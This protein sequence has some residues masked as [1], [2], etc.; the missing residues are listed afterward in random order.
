MRVES[1]TTVCSPLLADGLELTGT[2][3]QA[4]E[5]LAPPEF[6][7]RT[8]LRQ[9]NSK[10]LISGFNQGY[11]RVNPTLKSAA[12][13]IP[14]TLCDGSTRE[15]NNMGLRKAL[16]HL[17]MRV[18]RWTFTPGHPLPERCVVL[19]APHTSNWDGFYMVVAM[20]ALQRPFYFLV[21]KNLTDVPVI[22]RFVQAIGGIPVDRENPG[23]LVERVIALAQSS[24]TFVLVIAP[25]GTR[26]IRPYWKSGFYRI[27]QGANLPVVPG[28]IDGGQRRYGWGAPIELSGNQSK[29]MDAIRAFYAGI[30]G[31]HPEK[32]CVPRLRSEEAGS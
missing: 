3:S 20:W 2:P 27:A 7:L 19:G 5:R 12:A 22:G 23:H 1:D 11:F 15:R 4:E 24:E 18:S 25:K 16:A 9:L 26:S 14:R 17:V 10:S 6:D 30:I 32:T 8:V 13:R 31:I 29:D 28:F 21:K